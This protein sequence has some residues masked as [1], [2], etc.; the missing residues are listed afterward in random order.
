M[1]D[2]SKTAHIDARWQAIA[3][4]VLAHID[5]LAAQGSFDDEVR[6]ALAGAAE[7]VALGEPHTGTMLRAIA[8]FDERLDALAPAQMRGAAAMGRSAI[9]VG[10][11]VSRML[12]R[13]S[14]V[15]LGLKAADLI[16]A[17]LRLASAHVVTMLPIH[18]GGQ[19]LQPTTFAGLLGGTTGP[20]LRALDQIELALQQVNQCPMGGAAGT[21]AR[22]APD[23]ADMAQRL[24]FS[25][26]VPNVYDAVSSVDYLLIIVAAM[27]TGV[28]AV[29]R[30]LK[31]LQQL[32]LAIPEAIVF[33]DSS[34]EALPEAPQLRRAASFDA[35]IR[36]EKRAS[37]LLAAARASILS[38]DPGPQLDL[39]DALSST[40]NA[41]DAASGLME[42]VRAL[43][44]GGFE[45]NR[46]ILG[47][48]A[49]KG[50]LTSSDIVDFLV[51]EEGI[52][53]SDARL[54]AQRVLTLVR[55]QGLEI[56]A[57]DREMID[58]AGLLIV[59][60]EIGIEFETLS[61]YLAPRR[62]LENRTGLGAPSPDSTRDWITRETHRAKEH[63]EALTARKSEARSPR[64]EDRGL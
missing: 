45:I 6:S 39:D 14:L 1:T 10:Q 2:D 4:V 35:A 9:D 8:S 34:V 5:A 27:D 37:S 29:A 24:D 23:R 21:S 50:H 7:N 49:G 57:V 13:T 18:A 36:L 26:P 42:S 47:N 60:R 59:G 64:S 55:D 58:R 51:I 61:K 25:R 11:T 22:F 30:F 62:F 41:S 15:H 63:R 48:R 28:M 32:M 19:P 52:G 31:E 17:L 46:A 3:R 43:A 33:A 53:P 12:L 54:I 38:L 56:A 44:D 20:L 40:Q 16:E